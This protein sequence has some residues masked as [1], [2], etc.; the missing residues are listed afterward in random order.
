[1]TLLTFKQH[2]QAF[3]VSHYQVVTLTLATVKIPLVYNDNM[4]GPSVVF[5]KRKK[6]TINYLY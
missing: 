2:A 6:P 1:M 4:Y 5:V 3:T